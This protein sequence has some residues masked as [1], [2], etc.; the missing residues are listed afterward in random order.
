MNRKSIASLGLS[1]IGIVAIASFEGYRSNAYLDSVG[2][3]TIGYGETKNVKLGDKTTPDKALNQLLIS[4][5]EHTDGIKKCIKVPLFQYELDAYSSLAYNIG[6]SA[7]CNSTLVK[8]LNSQDYVGACEEIKRW[9]KAGGKIN[10]GLVKRR[11]I[12]YKMCKGETF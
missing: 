10:N 7:F 6:V 11:E 4:S 1:A 12:E 5:K 3:P 9:N 8:K 2:V